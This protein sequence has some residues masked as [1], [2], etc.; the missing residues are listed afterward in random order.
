MPNTN[1]MNPKSETS[2]NPPMV[3][4]APGDASYSGLARNGSSAA[5]S[6]LRMKT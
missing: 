1:P 6:V 5:A 3:Y 2:G 4:L